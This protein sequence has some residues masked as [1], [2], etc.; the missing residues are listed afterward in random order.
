MIS[1]ARQG[2]RVIDGVELVQFPEMAG[3]EFYG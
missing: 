2:G 1:A 3:P